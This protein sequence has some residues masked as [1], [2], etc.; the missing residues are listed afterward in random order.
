MKLIWNREL[1]KLAAAF[2]LVF[3]GCIF[4]LNLCI[5]NYNNHMRME[6]NGLTAVILGNIVSAYPEVSEEDLIRVLNA[7]GAKENYDKGAAVLAQYGIFQEYGSESFFFQ[8][9]QL[10]FFSQMVNFFVILLFSISFFLLFHYFS[11]RQKKISD[12]KNYMEA[13]NRDNYKLELEDNADD[14]LS[15]LRN[16]IYKL[17]VLLKEQARRAEEQRHVLADSIADISHQ[18]KT[19]LTS[20]TVLMSNLSENL[21]M[22]AAV[23]QRFMMEITRQLTGMTW[24]ITAMLKLSR[25]DAGVVTLECKPVQ[26]KDLVKEVIQKVEIAAEWKEITFSQSFPE[27]SV[28][29]ADRKWTAE[30]L[31]NIVKNAIEHSPVGSVIEISGE[32]NDV[33]TQIAVKD[34]GEGMTEEEREKLFRRFY[35][36]KGAREDSIGIGLSLA[37][38]IIEKQGGYISVHTRKQKGTVFEIRFL[39]RRGG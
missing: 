3:S 21:D 13:L 19:P 27:D 31:M 11:I 32:E 29:M 17:T 33:Y 26:L 12:L 18:L 25:L 35:N 6:Y 5:W 24:L 14:E 7:D 20:V 1:K 9:R 4:I 8:E 23:R 15:G 34:H 16:E 36:G 2:L 30:A 22:D 38:G 10:L 37:K 39:K 28:L